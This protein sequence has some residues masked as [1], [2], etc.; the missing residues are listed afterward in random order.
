MKFFH[1]YNDWHLEGLEKN[2]LINEDTGFKIQHAF[3]V[4]GELK[5]N[6]FAAKGGKLHS[7]IKEN[8]MPFY[9]DRITGGITYHNYNFDKEL[10]NEYESILGD[11]FLG[12]Q[13]HES[14]SNIFDSDLAQILKKMD[15]KKGPYDVEEL[16]AKFVLKK[17]NIE[18]DATLYGFSHDTPENYA[19]ITYPDTPKA[20]LE[21]M[22][23]RYKRY[24]EDTAHHIL[25]VDSYY[26]MS[27]LHNELGAK[28]FMPEVGWQIEQTRL[29]VA[30]ARGVA[31]GSGKL[32]GLYYEPWFIDDE[33]GYTI[34]NFNKE[35]ENEW[36]HNEQNP[37]PIVLN[38]GPNG[39][40]SGLLQSRIYHYALMA[41]ADY[42]S[43]EWGHNC[44]YASKKTFELSSYGLIKKDFIEFA[45]GYKTVKPVI[46]F[47][48]VLPLEY[49]CV[50]V[51]YPFE[52][53]KMGVHRDK[54][55]QCQ[56]S[57]ERRA[58]NGYVEDVIS[59]IYEM[60][61]GPYG[62]E[63]HILT[64]S[65][66]GDLFDIIYEDADDKTFA[67]YEGLIDATPDCR[68]SKKLGDK[69]R[70]FESGDLTKLEHDIKEY[71]KEVLP[72]TVDG[73]LWVVSEDEKGRYLSIFNNEGNYRSR[74]TGDKIDHA[75]DARVKVSFK[76]AANLKAIK[77]SSPDI[78][79][80]KADDKT[81]FIDM[82]ACEFAIF[83][84]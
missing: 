13:L 61:G 1:V 32:W 11:W 50:Q 45:R 9:I 71:S 35:V 28:T 63:S 56:L 55:M 37:V 51:A 4:P 74:P 41:G 30:L 43:E 69:Y 58:F 46:P 38:S 47:A 44:S 7:L 49:S 19:K 42:M 70:V 80:E 36:Y 73:L 17:R 23:N 64:N 8:K 18:D 57:P 16:K 53:Y 26:L 48:I 84:Y 25:P 29:A 10:L 75:A 39:G 22:T 21:F 2:N 82:P 3:S 24:L 60:Y 54:Y 83:R 5:F 33:L 31:E 12:I 79:I 78:K 40:P 77:L 76:E 65:R 6:K 67:K 14:A 34:P 27:R 72:V 62:N 15:G 66:F 59:L 52:P 20:F 81:Y 68:V